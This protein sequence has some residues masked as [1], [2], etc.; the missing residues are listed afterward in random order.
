MPVIR[1]A[2]VLKRLGGIS[3]ATLL[4]MESRG[5]FPQ[6]VWLSDGVFGWVEEEV[7][8]W[9]RSRERGP[10]AAVGSRDMVAARAARRRKKETEQAGKDDA[11]E[12][13]GDRAVSE[14]EISR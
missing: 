6:R 11:P 1:K 10:R 7:E 4:R 3:N 5:D 9:I 14:E 13:T 2:E 12:A 8:A